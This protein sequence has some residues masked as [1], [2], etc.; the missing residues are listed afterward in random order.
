MSTIKTFADAGALTEAAAHH[1]LERLR[2]G[3][4]A[5]GMAILALAGGSTPRA[6]YARLAQR[7]RPSQP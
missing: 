3:I 1:V 5:R 4:D 7:P 2:A 6:L